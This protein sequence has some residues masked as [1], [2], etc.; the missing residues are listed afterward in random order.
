MNLALTGRLALVCGSSAGLGRACA[1]ALLK[2]GAKVVLNGRD[3][4][5]LR[6]A[7]GEIS[8]A[9]KL[10]VPFVVADVTTA[11]GRLA[12]KRTCAEPDILV[13]NSAGPATGNYNDWSA[14]DWHDAID[15]S[16]VTPIMIIK[17]YLGPMRLCKWGRIV[18]ITS[19][20]V[21][22]PLP[23]LGLSNGARSGLNG[24]CRGP[25]A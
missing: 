8:Q 7:A 18:N 23:L 25:G 9:L 11:E 3:A 24:L 17:G 6:V 13:T 14:Q 4:E 15:A 19:S 2:A 22:A 21:K 10:E 12:V 16:M 20:A 1:E 5:R